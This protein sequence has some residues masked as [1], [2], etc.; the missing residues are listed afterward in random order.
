MKEIGNIQ[1]EKEGEMNLLKEWMNDN[2][3]KKK[4]KET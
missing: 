1:L 4:M 2:R 3:K